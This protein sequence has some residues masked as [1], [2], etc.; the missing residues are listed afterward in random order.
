MEV[1]EILLPLAIILVVSK[2]LMKCCEKIRFPAVIGMLLS[3]ILVGLIRYIPGQ[4]VLTATG[5]EGLAFFAKIG[6]I[7]ILFT[8]GLETDLQKIK[9]I[10]GPAVVITVAGVAVPMALGFLVATLCNGGFGALTKETLLQN[11]F[12]GTILTATSVSVTVATLREAGKLDSKVGT[13]IV[14]AAIIDDIL[15]IVVLSFVLA[16]KGDGAATAGPTVVVIRTLLYFVAVAVVAFLASKFFTVLDRRFEHHRLVPI[17]GIAFCFIIAYASEKWFGIADIT[18]A[19][20]VGLILSGNKDSHYIDRKADIM[21]Y[22]LFVPIFFANIGISTEFSD[23]SVSFLAFGAL[24]ILAGMVGKFLGCG[25]AALACGYKPQDAA[26][27]GLGMMA[28][29]EVALVTAQKGVEYGVIHSS[30]MPFVVAL[31]LITSFVTPLLLHASYRREVQ[32]DT[33]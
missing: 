5:M 33:E 30:I 16:L 31:I 7:L 17:M 2:V 1:Y 13:T 9:S 12:Y 19:Y 28:R 22:M 24:F 3:G 21:G 26:R 23:I 29:A 10:G 15:G 6:V 20:I 8:A 25:A 14:A 18:G 27:V 11:L 4:T 32:H